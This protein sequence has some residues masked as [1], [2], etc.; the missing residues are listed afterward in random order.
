MLV[1]DRGAAVEALAIAKPPAGKVMEFS[2]GHSAMDIN[3][4]DITTYIYIYNYT[5][6]VYPLPR[7]SGK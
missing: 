1:Q 5:Y 4:I 6:L 7:Y 2:H 3:G